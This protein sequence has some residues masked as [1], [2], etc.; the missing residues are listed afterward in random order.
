M[1]LDK[2]VIKMKNKLN[3]LFFVSMAAVYVFQFISPLVDPIRV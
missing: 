2:G 3:R 1:G